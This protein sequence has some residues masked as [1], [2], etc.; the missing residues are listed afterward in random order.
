MTNQ[1]PIAEITRRLEMVNDEALVS[2][3][4]YCAE[5]LESYG[6]PQSA[7]YILSLPRDNVRFTAQ[8]IRNTLRQQVNVNCRPSYMQF[9]VYKRRNDFLDTRR[10]P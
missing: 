2:A 1:E 5:I 4:Y 3:V 6:N 8:H 7:A 10:I 9:E